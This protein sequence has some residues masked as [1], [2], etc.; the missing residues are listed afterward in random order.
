MH[1][2]FRGI[3]WLSPGIDYLFTALQCQNPSDGSSFSH[4]T[5]LAG[6]VVIPS[7]CVL[8]DF[9]DTII[10]KLIV[11]SQTSHVH[12]AVNKPNIKKQVFLRLECPNQRI[13]FVQLILETW[14]TP[15]FVFQIW[16]FLAA[17]YSG[18]KSVTNN[19]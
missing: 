5:P 7:F 9:F 13:Q 19:L 16:F 1:P 18:I 8:L 3:S 4:P 12:R 2:R 17:L 14:R 15:F 11:F 6:I 10:A